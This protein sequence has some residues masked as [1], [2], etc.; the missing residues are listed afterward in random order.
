[1]RVEM[2]HEPELVCS[3]C[4]SDPGLI[5]F[6]ERNKIPGYCSFCAGHSGNVSVALF[7]E[8]ADHIKSCLY[9]EYDDPAN[10]M[11]WDGAEGGYIG[12]HW[13]ADE[14]L[15]QDIGLDFPQDDDGKLSEAIIDHISDHDWCEAEP[16]G[17]NDM[18]TARFSW[19]HFRKIV[20]H[21]RRFS[22]SDDP[23][24][25]SEPG[26]HSPTE[27]L[28]KI[29]EYAESYDLFVTFPSG[30]QLFRARFQGSGVRLETAQDLG[31]PPEGMATQSNRMSPPGIP[32]FYAGENKETA[33]RETANGPG[34]FV[35]GCFE[36]TRP[37]VLLDLTKVPPVPSLFQEI[38]KRPKSR[39]RAVLGFL[40]HIVKEMS[41]P[42][43][44]GERVHIEYVPTQVVTEYIRSKV[45]QGDRQIDGIKYSSAVH[46][47]HAAYV[48]FATQDNLILKPK[49]TD[50]LS[51]LG[52]DRWLELTGTDKYLVTQAQIDQWKAV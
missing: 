43:E 6:V 8:V 19:E 49:E 13:P 9:Q 27:V 31:P 29:F 17:L 1:M 2:R 51:P 35:V 14:F 30:T 22:F 3:N 52:E 34:P 11:G 45:I 20:M 28:D 32:M 23:G 38:P 48:L 26:V 44:R 21:Q 46:P 36:T 5:A 39:P 25:P 4:F 18:E 40:H 24:D 41:Q 16:Y 10:C 12:F 33:L 42:I 47:G 50:S 15:F 37:A 7:K